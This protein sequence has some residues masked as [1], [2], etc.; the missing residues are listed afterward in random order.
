[1]FK[2]WEQNGN[3]TKMHKNAGLVFMFFLCDGK[4]NNASN[5]MDTLIIHTMHYRERVKENR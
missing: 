3:D 2:L 4:S 1:M 5:I